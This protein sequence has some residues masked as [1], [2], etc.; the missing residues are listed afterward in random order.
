ML[1][2][3]HSMLW[4][5]DP[6]LLCGPMSRGREL[7]LTIA[8]PS[9]VIA[10]HGHAGGKRLIDYGRFTAAISP[11]TGIL[12]E[13]GQHWEPGSIAQTRARSRRCSAMPA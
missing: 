10:D 6:L 13:A 8:T 4:P 3:M 2:D 1:L 5:S 11:A 7:A 9:V 12:V